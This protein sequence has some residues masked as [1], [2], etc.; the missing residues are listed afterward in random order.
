M[1]D[2][3][4]YQANLHRGQLL[5]EVGRYEEACRFFGE[6]ISADPDQPQ[7]YLE[8]ALAKSELP[9]RREESL[10][11]MDRAVALNP[12]S[13]FFLG[14]KAYLLAYFDR[15]SEALEVRNRAL[16]I[17]PSCY[18]ALLAQAN[19][20]TKLARWSDVELSARSIL[21][22]NAED[23][24]AL[25]LLAQSLRFQGRYAES[26]AVVKVILARVPND[27]FGHANAGYEA[28]K[29]GDH[30]RAIQHFL[31]ALRA[32]PHYDFARRGLLQSLRSR[33]WIYRLNFKLLMIFSN[34]GRALKVALIFL[35]LLTGGIFF[36]L[37]ILYF[38]VA[39]SLQP[40][41]NFF[42]LFNSTGRRALTKRE[43]GQGLLTGI[44]AC[45]VL[46]L[47]AW[48]AVI[49]L[50]IVLAGYLFLFALGVLIPQWVDA[51]DKRR[52]EKLI[53]MEHSR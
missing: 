42:L 32:D 28:L 18:M 30:R 26:R 12:N 41:S 14:C 21:Q 16:E 7:P 34:G 27:P 53:V 4:G 24:A 2:G 19:A 50:E 51:W 40:L 13:A 35:S 44:G 47:L 36:G 37:L 5:K 43:Q 11:A 23:C 39:Y 22:M 8:M 49:G 6:A 17:D 31:N 9:G 33:I 29:T 10:Q 38:P 46:F 45:L 3:L 48:T 25:N 1:S 15:A 20:Y 52:E